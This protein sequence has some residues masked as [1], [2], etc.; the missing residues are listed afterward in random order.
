[1][2]TRAEL[3]ELHHPLPSLETER[4]RLEPLRPQH[5]DGLHEL[6]SNS[7]VAAASDEKATRD[8]G[9]N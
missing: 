6:C 9:H 4:L 2:F 5:I 7:A 8:H 3:D 1:M